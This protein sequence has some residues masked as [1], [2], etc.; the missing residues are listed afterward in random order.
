LLFQLII[1]DVPAEICPLAAAR[2]EQ[3]SS[4]A[5]DCGMDLLRPQNDP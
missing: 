4:K 5:A 1:Q 3:A 2:W